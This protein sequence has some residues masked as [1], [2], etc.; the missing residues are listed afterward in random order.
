VAHI[1]RSA[2]SLQSK[3]YD[4][5]GPVDAGAK[6]ARRGE[7][8]RQG[9]FALGLSGGSVEWIGNGHDAKASLQLRR[10][11]VAVNI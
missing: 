2:K 10:S 8:N 4:L 11:S 3:L 1:D 9:R 6:A 5:N 7:Q